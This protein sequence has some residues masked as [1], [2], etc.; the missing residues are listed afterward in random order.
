MAPV[1][2][3]GG[4]A[5]AAGAEGEGLVGHMSGSWLGRLGGLLAVSHLLRYERLQFSME[6]EAEFSW[7][8]SAFEDL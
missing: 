8:L 2:S 3:L 4:E 7:W 1:L 5:S 6:E